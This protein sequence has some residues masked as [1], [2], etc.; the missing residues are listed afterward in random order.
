MQKNVEI[1]VMFADVSGS[2][3]LYDTAGDAV[4]FAAVGRV[5]AYL[6][7]TAARCGGRVIKTI[8]DEVMCAFPD[9]D[10]ATA[11]A[12]EMQLGVDAMPA[13]AGAPLAIR[14]GFHF[15]PAVE[16]D[17]DVFGD[18]VNLAARLSDLAIRGQVI[19]SRA[20]VDRLN[21]TLR[22]SCRVLYATDVKGKAEA[23]EI[24]EVLW[25]DTDEATTLVV[26]RPGP[27]SVPLVLTLTY[28]ER[29]VVLD[30]NR[31]SVTLGRDKTA[32]LTVD[33]PKA[34]RNHG[35]IELRS[36]KFML[37]DHSANGTYLAIDGDKEYVLRREEYPLH[38]HGWITLGQSRATATEVVEYRCE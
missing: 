16:R 17:G 38:G 4:A 35:R 12:L 7:E 2:T 27:V 34:S 6:S 8:G 15:G 11:A 19:T 22:A 13:V 1:A 24:C 29:E 3:K 28:R 23:V 20:T 33:E 25:R 36:G 9:A 26:N 10:A 30:A 37:V 31:R 21:P 14:V 18:S 5:V 32:E